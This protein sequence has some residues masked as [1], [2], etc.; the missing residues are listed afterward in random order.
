MG[1]AQDSNCETITQD[2]LEESPQECLCSKFWC[3]HKFVPWVVWARQA[4]R[5]P[6]ACMWAQLGAVGLAV[7]L[8][9][10]TGAAVLC[11]QSLS[12]KAHSRCNRANLQTTGRKAG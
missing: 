5:S 11:R 7:V 2:Y 3:H 9:A 10:L 4:D 8:G 6:F 1:D 12:H